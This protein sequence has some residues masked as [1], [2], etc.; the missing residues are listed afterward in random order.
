MSDLTIIRRRVTRGAYPKAI[1]VNAD[2]IQTV[3]ADC[4]SAARLE[5]ESDRWSL[6]GIYQRTASAE[7]IAEDV[8]FVRAERRA[9][10]FRANPYNVGSF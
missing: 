4:D 5:R 8:A 10:A 6:V 1:F 9:A 2:G 3:R 7:A